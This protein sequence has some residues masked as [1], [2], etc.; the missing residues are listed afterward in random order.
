MSMSPEKVVLC[1]K[2]KG[3]VCPTTGHKAPFTVVRFEILTVVLLKI[4]V[5]CDVKTLQYV[6]SSQFFVLSQCLHFLSQAVQQE[7]LYS[8]G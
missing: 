4:Q 2:V 1:L 7:N 5:F 3:K 6:N 8:H